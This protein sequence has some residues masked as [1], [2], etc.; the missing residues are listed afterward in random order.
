MQ[1]VE[2]IIKMIQV[3]MNVFGKFKRLQLIVKMITSIVF[4]IIIFLKKI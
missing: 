4:M 1:S 3:I 2:V